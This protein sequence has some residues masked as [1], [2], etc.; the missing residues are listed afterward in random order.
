MDITNIN[1][2]HDDYT[3]ILSEIL[4]KIFMFEYDK[5][6]YYSK[7]HLCLQET[8]K[9]VFIVGFDSYITSLLSFINT[10]VLTSLNERMYEGKPF[11]WIIQNGKTLS[12][13]SPVNA[14]ILEH[15]R[16]IVD[17]PDSLRNKKFPDN[18]FIKFKFDDKDKTL[19]KLMHGKEAQIWYERT[20]QKLK[21]DIVKI[22]TESSPKELVTQY[23][24][25]KLIYSIFEI[26]PSN[27]RIRILNSLFS[28]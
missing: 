5:N 12:I 23:D 11:G 10:L 20:G 28:K 27:E 19:K 21:N 24:G 25:G 17:A 2:T 22:L 14:T 6:I 4:D 9:N 3:K 8:E 16:K 1:K 7:N 13:Y 18:W 26:L 15:N